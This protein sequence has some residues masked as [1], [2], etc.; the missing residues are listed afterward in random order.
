MDAITYSCNK[1]IPMGIISEKLGYLNQ[2]YFWTYSFKNLFYL[3]LLQRM[4]LTS[5]RSKTSL[6]FELWLNGIKSMMN[7]YNFCS[8]SRIS[9]AFWLEIASAACHTVCLIL[10]WFWFDCTKEVNSFIYYYLWC[11]SYFLFTLGL[12]FYAHPLSQRTCFNDDCQFNKGRFTESPAITV[13][14]SHCF[15][16]CLVFIMR[17]SAHVSVISVTVIS[18]AGGKFPHLCTGVSRY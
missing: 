13:I 6:T 4:R 17:P 8:L 10:A 1:F 7:A 2:I 3:P 14:D 18:I 9:S 12:N 16:F 11:F 5:L 15:V